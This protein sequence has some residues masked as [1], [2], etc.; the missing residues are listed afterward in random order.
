MAIDKN[1]NLPFIVDIFKCREVRKNRLNPII[2]IYKITS[3]SGKIYIGLSGDIENRFTQ[4]R[5]LHCEFQIYLLNSLKKH[6]VKN[7]IFEIIH[8]CDDND[9]E[10]EYW[11]FYYGEL[12]DVNNKYKGL[13]IRECGGRRGKLSKETKKKLS[14]S[15]TGE[16]NHFFGKKHPAKRIKLF[17]ELKKGENN[18]MFGN[19]RSEKFIK[20]LSESRMGESNPFYGEN[21]SKK[22]KKK[23]SIAKKKYWA[24]VKQE[25]LKLK[26]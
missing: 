7:H 11:E 14:E 12:F 8:L 23:L 18:P 22:T 9:E 10:L 24:R 19:K 26:K 4:Y 5:I 16:K 15:R 6:G 3:P 21:H 25:K 2:G 20:D 1:I 17:S 13:N